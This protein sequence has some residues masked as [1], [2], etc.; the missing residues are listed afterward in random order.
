MG[1]IP[2][3]FRLYADRSVEGVF[4]IATR[5]TTTNLVAEAHEP[6]KTFRCWL[7]AK[8]ITLGSLSNTDHIAFCSGLNRQILDAIL[9]DC[10]NLSTPQVLPPAIERIDSII[11][12]LKKVRDT[13][14]GLC[15]IPNSNEHSAQSKALPI[16][17]KP[18]TSQRK[19]PVKGLSS[20]PSEDQENCFSAVNERTEALPPCPDYKSMSVP[21]LKKLMAKYGYRAGTKAYMV[22]E[23]TL[24]WQALHSPAEPAP[25]FC[26]QPDEPEAELPPRDSF[27]SPVRSRARKVVRGSP[28]SFNKPDV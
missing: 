18:G 11:D 2:L 13:L 12:R 1:R 10:E 28:F 27:R 9:P 6:R 25:D 8:T 5:F 21:E 14:N 20:I 16:R 24:A 3:L 15:P 22:R 17:S 19:L 4:D 23:L 7:C 26:P